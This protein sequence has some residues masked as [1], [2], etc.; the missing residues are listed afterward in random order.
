MADMAGPGMSDEDVGAQLQ[1]LDELLSEVESVPGPA[2]EIAVDAVSTLAGV[3][4]EA[5]QRALACTVGEAR[6][7]FLE[8]ELLRHLLVLH[9]IHPD[10]V[11]VRVARAVGDLAPVVAEQ[12]GHVEFA[13]L[14][15]EV[16][17]IRLS[18]SGCGSQGLG[19]AVREAVLGI[20]P[21][22]SDVMVVAAQKNQ[23]A[24]IPLDLVAAR[25]SLDGAQP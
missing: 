11:E 14:D 18:A 17:T 5:L 10:P 1:R 24:F 13:G 8:D 21:E 12:G 23:A 7:R 3:Y 9:D 19:D 4:G 20:A 2:G 16:A 22:L 6:D 25:P 15:G